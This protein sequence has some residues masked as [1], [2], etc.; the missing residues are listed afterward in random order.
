MARV[1][2]GRG[3]VVLFAKG[4]EVVSKLPTVSRVERLDGISFVGLPGPAARKVI[5]WMYLAKF[6]FAA[7]RKLPPDDPWTGAEIRSI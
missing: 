2:E 3:R 1:P 6:E 7:V 5:R 4:S